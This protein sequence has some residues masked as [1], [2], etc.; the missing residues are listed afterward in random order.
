M[1]SK[2]RRLVFFVFPFHFIRSKTISPRQT[3]IIYYIPVRLFIH[4]RTL[5]IMRVCLAIL[6][7][8]TIFSLPSYSRTLYA[9]YRFPKRVAAARTPARVEIRRNNPVD[10]FVLRTA[11]MRLEFRR[12]A[13]RRRNTTQRSL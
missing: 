1:Y 5:L 8:Y 6:C 13:S 12:D 4:R 11:L 10:S 7:R 3:D 9:A 2:Q